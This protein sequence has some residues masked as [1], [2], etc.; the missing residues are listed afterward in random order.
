MNKRENLH[1][2][3]RKENKESIHETEKPLGEEKIVKCLEEE[4]CC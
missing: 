1:E 3:R 2:K 4:T